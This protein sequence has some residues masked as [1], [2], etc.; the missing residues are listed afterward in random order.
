MIV[1]GHI[2]DAVRNELSLINQCTCLGYNQTYECTIATEGGA[3]IWR[4]TAIDCPEID[5]EIILYNHPQEFSER[6]SC[7]SRP[8]TAYGVRIEVSSYISRLNITVSDLSMDNRSV[9]CIYSNGTSTVVGLAYI[10][11]TEGI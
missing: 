3:T 5:D 10:D 1:S 8:I 9:Q 7:Y 4:G 2:I 6:R 11:I